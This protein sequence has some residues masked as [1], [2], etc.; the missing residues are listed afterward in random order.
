[1]DSEGL[2]DFYQ[3]PS[4]HFIFSIRIFFYSTS[5]LSE[6]SQNHSVR[7]GSKNRHVP[8]LY[9]R[10]ED[11]PL[12]CTLVGDWSESFESSSLFLL[13]RSTMKLSFVS[14]VL[15]GLASIS[16]V[17]GQQCQK[18]PLDP[19]CT[20]FDAR[21]QLSANDATNLNSPDVAFEA[22]GL[23]PGFLS[24]SCARVDSQASRQYCC[25]EKETLPKLRGRYFVTK[26]PVVSQ[27]TG[28]TLFKSGACVTFDKMVG[29]KVTTMHVKYTCTSNTKYTYETFA[30]E[31]CTKMI[32]AKQTFGTSTACRTLG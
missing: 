4:N 26:F 29:K 23:C 11:V 17:N 30:D 13:Q 22:P 10:L 15:A 19:N 16:T 12:S 14:A 21:W 3:L 9:I 6:S 18:Y 2:E 20:Q 25:L 28:R 32:G 1:M 5:T 31:R 24:R 27:V 7:R 8:I